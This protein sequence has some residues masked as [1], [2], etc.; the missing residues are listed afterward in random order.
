[1]LLGPSTFVLH[2]ALTALF[3][4]GG[5]FATNL[6]IGPTLAKSPSYIGYS[7]SFINLFYYVGVFACTPLIQWLAETSGWGAVTTLLVV[8]S[9]VSTVFIGIL[10]LSQKSPAARTAN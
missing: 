6:C 7:M 2:V 10:A 4:G 5:C 8:V 9:I 3:I 1:M